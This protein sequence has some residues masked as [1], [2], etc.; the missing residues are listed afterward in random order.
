MK[1]FVYYMPTVGRVKTVQ[2][3]REKSFILVY[4]RLLNYMIQ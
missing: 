3:S 1:S 2:A 4:G